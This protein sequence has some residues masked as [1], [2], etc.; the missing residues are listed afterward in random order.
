VKKYWSLFFP[1]VMSILIFIEALNLR[2]PL[3]SV[4]YGLAGAG[5]LI[6]LW[7]LVS[8]IV[9]ARKEHLRKHI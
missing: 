3:T 1:L 8:Q 4:L 5:F 6:F 7:I 9:L 2:G